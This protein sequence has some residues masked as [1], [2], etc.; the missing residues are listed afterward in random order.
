[1]G[2]SKALAGFVSALLLSGQVQA[3]TLTGVKGSVMV[4][5]GSGFYAAVDPTNLKPGDVVMVKPGGTAQ[6]TYPD[7]CVVPLETGAV[8]TVG[9]TS[10]CAGQAGQGQGAAW[11]DTG[12]LVIGTVIVAGLGAIF[13]GAVSGSSS[14]GG[15]P[16]SP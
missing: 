5:P 1:M 12:T 4:N 16:A 6:L 9:E 10:P 15:R 8:F 2:K 7:G 11:F 14:D 13:L 3:A